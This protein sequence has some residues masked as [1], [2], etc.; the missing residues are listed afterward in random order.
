MTNSNSTDWTK[1]DTEDTIF[2]CWTTED[3]REIRPDLTD[4]ECRKILRKVK[5]GHDAT[6]GISWDV[7]ETISYDMY[8][9]QV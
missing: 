6:L 7:I 4:H 8:P 2:V 9:I 5:D 3:I 1:Y